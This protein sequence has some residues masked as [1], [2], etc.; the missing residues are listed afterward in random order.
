VAWR[1]RGRL[2]FELGRTDKAAA[3]LRKAVE[4]L[5]DK[6]LEALLSESAGSETAEPLV[7][8]ADDAVL[9]KLTTAVERTSEDASKLWQWG[10]WHARHR[11]WKEAAA[12]FTTALQRQP[13]ADAG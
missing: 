9:Q 1:N 13:T 8:L 7:R 12:D 4:L 2:Y 3:D 6:A 11:R 10:A 5:D